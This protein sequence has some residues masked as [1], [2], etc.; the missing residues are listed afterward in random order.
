M[1]NEK[2]LPDF[3]YDF[4]NSF[5]NLERL[6][7][8]SQIGT[9]E[10]KFSKN[11]NNLI[12]VNLRVDAIKGSPFSNMSKINSLVFAYGQ[13]NHISKNALKIGNGNSNKIFSIT[14]VNNKLN[15]SSFENGLFTQTL[16]KNFQINLWLDSNQI[17][18]LDEA[19]F[20]PFLTS[21]NG[22][23]LISIF[24][25]PIDCDDCRSAWI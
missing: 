14:L 25:N 18:Y 4:A 12:F 2:S 5:E 8:L 23:I 11:L 1:I 7:Y 21:Q 13:L 24:D 6:T 3:F 9:L 10:E 19:A 15:G 17:Y 20:S 22:N 16:F